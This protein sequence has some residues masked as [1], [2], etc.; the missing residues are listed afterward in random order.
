MKRKMTAP[1]NPLIAAA[2]FKK[3]GAHGKSIKARRR[4]EKMELQ[5]KVGIVA[6]HRTFNP[7]QECSNHSPSTSTKQNAFE[8]SVVRL[9]LPLLCGGRAVMQTAVNRPPKGNAGSIP[10]RTAETARN[11]AAQANLVEA[12]A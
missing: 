1:R 2:R 9:M 11:K 7:A 8:E 3:A 6:V 5:G 12:P 4:A 10:A